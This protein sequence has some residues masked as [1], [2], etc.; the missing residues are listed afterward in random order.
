MAMDYRFASVAD[1]QR[2]LS[3]RRSLDVEE[4]VVGREAGRQMDDLFQIGPA[5]VARP[6]SHLFQA[7]QYTHDLCR[8]QMATLG[9]FSMSLPLGFLSLWHEVI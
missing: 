1:A 9:H 6:T 4:M 3:W 2:H 7:A 8:E 5:E